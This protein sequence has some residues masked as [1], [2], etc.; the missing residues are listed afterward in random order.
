MG[1]LNRAE[2]NVFFLV[3]ERN[4][5]GGESDDADDDENYSD[6]GDWLHGGEAFP[7]QVDGM[8]SGDDL[9]VS[10]TVFLQALVD[11]SNQE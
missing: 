4:S 1:D 5:A 9:D 2:V 8:P 6:N 3:G 11:D 10:A 7:E